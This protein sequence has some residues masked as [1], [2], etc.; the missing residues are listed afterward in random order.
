MICIGEKKDLVYLYGFS[1]WLEHHLEGLVSLLR[2]QIKLNSNISVILMHDGVIGTSKK[3]ATPPLFRELLNLPIK[4]FA[5]I[6]DIKGRGI[7]QES[8]DEKVKPIEYDELVDILAEKPKI[9]S[10]L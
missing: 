10:W 9:F 7:N 2:R 6:P 5:M 8:I 4:V 1:L 3:G